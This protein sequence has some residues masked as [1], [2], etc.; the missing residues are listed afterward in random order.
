M[1]ILHSHRAHEAACSGLL[2][3][4]PGLVVRKHLGL[5][6]TRTSWGHTNQDGAN[7]LGNRGHAAPPSPGALGG[8]RLAGPEPAEE[9]PHPSP[10]ASAPPSRAA[11]PRRT[12]HRAGRRKT[13]CR[14]R[15][16]EWEQPK[17]R[18]A[19]KPERHHGVGNNIPLNK[20]ALPPTYSCRPEL[21]DVPFPLGQFEGAPGRRLFLT[22][23]LLP[24]TIRGS[25]GELAVLVCGT[26][27]MPS[28]VVPAQY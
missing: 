6:E 9:G 18:Q 12:Q 8:L 23:P 16:R 4:A 26:S 28:P 3:K 11:R 24:R 20:P 13:P 22:P 10:P 15:T 17:Q 25:T 21:C 14:S 5:T 19:P 27:N 1:P 2:S 7:T